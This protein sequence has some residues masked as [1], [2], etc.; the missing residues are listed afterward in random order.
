[1][2]LDKLAVY[3]LALTLLGDH[4]LVTVTDDVEARYVLDNSWDRAVAFVFQAAFWRFAIKTA[5]LS[6]NGALTALPGYTSTFA[7]PATYYH[8]HA[9]FVLSGTRECPVEIRQQGTT[10]HANT[11]PIYLRYVD[12]A[13]IGTVSSWPET[14]ANALGAYLAF[15]TAS[16]ISQDP[17]APDAMFAVWQQ[18]FG[19]AQAVEAI[20]PDPWLEAQLS[21]SFM[22]AVRYILAQ[23]FWKFALKTA[24]LTAIGGSPPPGYLNLYTKPADWI[25][26]QAIYILGG[27]RELPVDVRDNV[28]T[29]AGNV[30]SINVRYLSSTTGL[31]ATKWPDEFRN[32]VEAYIAA[33]DPVT[34][35]QGNTSTPPWV[36]MVQAALPSLTIPESGWL[37]HQLSGRFV[38]V[39]TALLEDGYWRF[40][41]KTSVLTA[42]VDTPS[43]GYGYAFDRPADWLRTFHIYQDGDANQTGIDFRDEEEQFHA[44]Y[45]PISL[46]YVSKT[47]GL[48]TT[49]WSGPFEESVLARLELREAMETQGTPGAVI[50][51]LAG[52][53]ERKEKQARANDDTR[54]RPRVNVPSRFV[55]GRFSGGWG[56]ST[57]EQG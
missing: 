39:V 4:R 2:A 45:S 19:S 16:R 6:H 38:N 11:T 28:D 26:T 21:G 18:Y 15:V 53:S 43:D 17:Q 3:N 13:L 48:D 25:K 7:L 50:A 47:L 22:P 31:D 10:L 35:S 54:E 51:A 32:I 12:S 30:A 44:N 14:V 34:D 9:I 49:Q 37:R 24:N 56:R 52:V 57:R 41:I 23:G 42:T 27:T 20:A 1:M 5:S 46:R 8:P 36:Q 40:A 55:N 29:W 33:R